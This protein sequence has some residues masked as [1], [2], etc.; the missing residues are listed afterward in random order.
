M[1]EEDIELFS[2][3]SAPYGVPYKQWLAKWW[4]WT[5]SLPTQEHPR[6]NYSPEKCAAGQRGPVWFL[7]DALT[8]KEERTCTIPAEKAILAPTIT[9]QCNYGRHMLMAGWSCYSLCHLVNMIYI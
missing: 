1:R 8:G 6:D 5:Q 2:K 3:D 9:G 4:N 7:A